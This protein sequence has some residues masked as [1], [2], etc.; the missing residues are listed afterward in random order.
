MDVKN[1]SLLRMFGETNVVLYLG[2]DKNR[3][4]TVKYGRFFKSSR[5][6]SEKNVKTLRAHFIRNHKISN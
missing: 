3:L 2:T 5:F 4:N 6:A 1:R